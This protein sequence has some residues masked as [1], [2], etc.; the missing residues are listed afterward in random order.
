MYTL[1]SGYFVYR[2]STQ[3]SCKASVITDE[4]GMAIIRSLAEH[5][6]KG[7]EQKS[8]EKQLQLHGRKRSEDVT[9]R[10]T[11][12]FIVSLSFNPKI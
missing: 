8:E 12:K 3:K 10:V 2:C 11:C 1:K 5:D 9:S 6:H 7:N 4:K